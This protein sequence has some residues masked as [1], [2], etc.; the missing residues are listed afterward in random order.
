MKIS[1]RGRDAVRMMLDIAQQGGQGFVALKDVAQ[2]QGISKKYL[3][4]IIPLLYNAGLLIAGRGNQGG[5]RLTKKPAEYSVRDILAVTEKLAVVAC[6][7][8]KENMC[9]RRGICKTL[10]LWQGLDK[11]INDYLQGVTLQD[12]IDKTDKDDT[13]L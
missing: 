9:P 11:V 12:L 8:E 6:L 1:T 7:E 5:Y 10:N 3:E 2:R 4:Q 13:I